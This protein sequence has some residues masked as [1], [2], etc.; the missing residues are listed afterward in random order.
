MKNKGYTAYKVLRR[1]ADG[2]LVDTYT[3]GIEYSIGK[4]TIDPTPH[5]LSVHS[6][7]ER[8]LNHVIPCTARGTLLPAVLVEVRVAAPVARDE[9][10][11]VP[12]LTVV[13]V[14]SEHP[15]RSVQRGFSPARRREAEEWLTEGWGD[16]AEG[17]LANQ[18]GRTKPESVPADQRSAWRIVV[19]P[20]TSGKYGRPRAVRAYPLDT[21]G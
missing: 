12:A 2:A 11:L 13:K 21:V 18:R 3:T 15:A 17:D 9:K 1:R 7:P 8:A 19:R 4:E 16:F 20:A 6:T 10:S 5:G 14:I